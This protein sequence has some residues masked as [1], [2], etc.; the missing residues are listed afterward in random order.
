MTGLHAFMNCIFGEEPAFV[1]GRR[2]SK[3]PTPRSG[4][5]TA[6]A[7]K[8]QP[9]SDFGLPRRGRQALQ[10]ARTPDGTTKASTYIE[11]E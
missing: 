7:G 5:V 4:L 8:T 10:I 3:R 9:A 1:I 6:N 2:A 11:A